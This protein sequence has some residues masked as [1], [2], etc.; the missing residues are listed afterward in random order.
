MTRLIPN[1]IEKEKKVLY[2][3][4]NGFDIAHGLPTSYE[5]FH[6]WLLDN[7]H[8]SFVRDFENLYPD[9]RDNKGRW[10]DVESAL[11]KISLKHAAE[12]DLYHQECPDEIR[13][14]NSSYD[15]YCC[16]DNLK[17]VIYVL[18]HLLREWVSSISAKDILPVFELCNDA[19]Y[20]S[21]N[22]TKTL[23]DIYIIKD[24]NILHIHETVIHNRPLVVGCGEALFDEDYDYTT[25]R[26]D[27]DLQIIRNILSHGKKPVEAILKEP[28]LKTW[29]ENLGEVSSV[30]VYGHSCSKVDK[31]YFET[32]A[33]FIQKD[34][35]WQFYVHDSS[36]NK[37]IEAF[38]QSI[39]K[40]QQKYE[41]IN[42]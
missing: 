32:V 22:Y 10:C 37:T 28:I 34:A 30:I 4:G 33:K 35:Y 19:C 39:M 3:V 21:F 27:V 31:A 41:I 8:K 6:Q 20:L 7:G 17:N 29:F 5:C 26:D 9:V 42:Q 38:A 16:G 1:N 12:Y 40:N 23:E 36:N 24:S 13:E 25:E 14:E 2:I 11:G 18:P 15:A